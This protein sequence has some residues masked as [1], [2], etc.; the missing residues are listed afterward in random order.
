MRAEVQRTRA[1]K[2]REERRLGISEL[3]ARLGISGRTVS[4]WVAA[5]TFPAPSYVGLNRKWLL[6][7]VEAWE[8]EHSGRP[9]ELEQRLANL[10]HA[11]GAP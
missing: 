1:W 2:G 4:R 7:E 6:S 9:P 11:Q 10:G 5:G 3:A 8:A